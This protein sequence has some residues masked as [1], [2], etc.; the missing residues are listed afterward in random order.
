M[1]RRKKTTTRPVVPPP[2]SAL[3]PVVSSA[4]QQPLP[5]RVWRVWLVLTLVAYVVLQSLYMTATPLQRMTLPDNLPRSREQNL[6]VGI[7]PDEKEHFLYILSLAEQ[8]VLPAPDP[9]RR[10]SPEQ[11]VTYQAQHPPLFY[12]LGALFYNVLPNVA[13]PLVWQILRAFCALCG[14]VVVVLTARAARIAF[15]NRPLIVLAAAPFAAFVPMFGH[16]TGNLSNEPL[17]MAFG[18]WAWLLMARIVRTEDADAA[19]RDSAWLGAALGLAA[20]TRLTALLWIPAAVAVMAYAATRETGRISLGALYGFAAWFVVL[21]LPWFAYNQATYGTPFLRTFD[22]PMMAYGSLADFAGDG[23][24]PPNAPM[25]LTPLSTALWYASTS[26]FPYWLV[27]F[28]LPGFS[29]AGPAWQ[30]L[31]LIIDVFVLL[32]LFLHVSR[33]RRGLTG[34]AHDAPGR[35][36]L[37]AASAAVGFC[38][39]VVLEQQFYS[40][41][42][43]VNSAGRYIIAALPASTLLFLF[44]F[45]TLVRGPG[46][47]ERVLAGGIAVMMVAFD[48]YTVSLVRRFYTDNPAQAAVQHI[49]QSPPRASGREPA[50]AAVR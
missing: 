26:W 7:G 6:I 21:L 27:Q 11:Y 48:L 24:R 28:Y 44:A 3:P 39:L 19:T 50:P 40:D 37:L 45:S 25:A 16:M 17:A 35:T 43:V 46:R 4:A 9:A 47:S 2:K 42:N 41:W 15:P 5:E 49:E 32:L 18:A 31:F 29:Q 20:V 34:E 22:R 23:I 1:A 38:V 12:A 30:A 14:A 10:A 13:L 8:G 36:L 33:S